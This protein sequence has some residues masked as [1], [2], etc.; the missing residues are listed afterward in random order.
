MIYVAVYFTDQ[1]QHLYVYEK[2]KVAERLENTLKIC[3]IVFAFFFSLVDDEM[4]K[5]NSPKSET[6]LSWNSLDKSY[7]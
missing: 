3:S 2:F 1:I 4:W 6:T 5:Q 7:S